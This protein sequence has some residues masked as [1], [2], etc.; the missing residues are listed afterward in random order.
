[1]REETCGRAITA[2]NFV[3]ALEEVASKAPKAIGS[4]EP[5]RLRAEAAIAKL[6]QL[7]AGD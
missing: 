1:M 3:A 6:R 4:F 2:N 7:Q 5:E